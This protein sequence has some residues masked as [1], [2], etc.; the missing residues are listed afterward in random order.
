MLQMGIGVRYIL[1]GYTEE[2]NE[3][4]ITIQVDDLLGEKPCCK[5]LYLS[6]DE[7]KIPFLYNFAKDDSDSIYEFLK[8]RVLPKN[9]MF[10]GE[11]LQKEFNSSEYNLFE[12]LKLNK[13]CCYDDDIHFEIEDEKIE[14]TNI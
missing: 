4:V 6:E 7:K 5:T 14:H 1:K 8:T 9:R 3:H 11:L 12:L 2:S 13:G 10:I